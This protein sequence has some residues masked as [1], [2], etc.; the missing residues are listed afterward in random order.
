M[1][2]APTLSSRSPSSEDRPRS[3][4]SQTIPKRTRLLNPFRIPEDRELF[5]IREQQHKKREAERRSMQDS[6]LYLSQPLTDRENFR[7][8]TQLPPPHISGEEE[9]L[10]QLIL[11]PDSNEATEGLRDFIDQKRDIFLAQLAI[12]TKREELQRLERL[13]RDEQS[14]LTQKETEVSFDKRDGECV[15]KMVRSSI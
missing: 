4:G 10:A 3:A 5:Q 14:A 6:R 9:A 1:D 8:L 15:G 11:S 2:A 7:K 13:E 12:D